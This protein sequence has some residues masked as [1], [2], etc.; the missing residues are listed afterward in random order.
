ML[1]GGSF[2]KHAAILA[3]GTAAGQGVTFLASPVL[4]RIYTPAEFGAFAVFF[5][6]VN[7]L[8]AF[9]TL[10]YEF[11]TPLPKDDASAASIV[12]LCL[13]A[14]VISS[15]ALFGVAWLWGESFVALLSLDAPADFLLLVPLG[16]FGY[17]L[18]QTLNYW[19]TRKERF[20]V[21]A[22]AKSGGATAA[23]VAQI[24]GEPFG[25]KGLAGG[26]IL[27]RLLGAAAMARAGIVTA[28]VRSRL[29]ILRVAREYRNFPL[30]T[31]W[32]T[33]VNAL[34]TQAPPFLLTAFY[35]QEIAGFFALTIRALMIPAGLVAQTVGQV[36]Y[37]RA[38][39]IKDDPAEVRRV[40]E[41]L[42]T[43]LLVVSLPL[44]ALVGF[45]GPDAFA[46]VFG[47][48]WRLSG[49]YARLVAPWLVFAFVSAPMS[50]LAFVRERQGQAFLI[51]LYETGLRIVA[52]WVGSRYDSP[53]LSI[54][55][56]GAAGAFITVFYLGWA[57][58]L[59][60]SGLLSW[61]KSMSEYL[62][63]AVVFLLL[64]GIVNFLGCVIFGVI[65]TALLAA[66]FVGWSWRKW[67]WRY[68]R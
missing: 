65:G 57:L 39:K 30:Y 26:Y 62:V 68:E 17:G 24:L 58:R 43:S 19:T 34:G 44:Y 21:L 66:A 50:T 4:T 36:F 6:A 7:V 40:A 55:L 3:L 63:G 12:A 51:T 42:A 45:L 10:R 49:E 64:T 11:A 35:S 59:A 2:G 54:G 67:L 25:A 14:L 28:L 60:G 47:E 16:V 61:L 37:P 23:V 56:Y 5:S 22:T 20:G 53:E 1:P 48:E 27:G 46:L 29:E 18:F 32:A 13:G 31:L 8:V 41:R 9:G 15:A 33:L 52:L 38:S